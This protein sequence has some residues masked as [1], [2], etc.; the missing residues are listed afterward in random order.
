MIDKIFPRKLNRSKDARIQD[1]TEMYNAINISIDDFDGDNGGADG[2]GDAGV[3]KP[4]K[5]NSALSES[6]NIEE[7]EY[8]RVIGSVADEVNNE[9]YLFVFSTVLSKQGVYKISSAEQVSPVYTSEYFNFQSNGFVKGDIVYRS[10]GQVM[11]FFTDG[12]NEPRKLSILKD[13]AYPDDASS[14]AQKIDLITACPKT[15]MMPPTFQFTSDPS[16]PVNFRSVEGFQFAYQCIYKS[17]EESAISTYSNV[18]IP[19]P[20]LSQGS[21][22]D[23]LLDAANKIEVSVPRIVNQIENFTENVESIRL[24]VRIGNDGAF[25]TV[26][27]K[28]VLDPILNTLGNSVNFDFYNDSV[29]TGVPQEDQDKLNDALPKKALSQTVVNDRLIYGNYEEGYKTGQ[30][31]ANFTTRN[32]QRPEDFVDLRVG[33]KS[34]IAPAFDEDSTTTSVSI[35]QDDFVASNSNQ[36]DSVLNRRSAYQFDLSELPSV[37]P[38][39]S[40]AE[41]SF[42]ISPD[43]NFHLYDSL[44]G[45]HTFKNNGFG[46]GLNR[47]DSESIQGTTRV[48]HSGQQVGSFASLNG[49]QP[50][51]YQPNSNGVQGGGILWRSTDPTASQETTSQIRFGTSPSNP[52]VVPSELVTFKVKFKTTQEF[53]GADNV[54]GLV[55][56]VLIT[57]FSNQESLNGIDGI[58]D[59]SSASENLQNRNPSVSVDQLMSSSNGY[60]VISDN[61]PISNTV[62]SCFTEDDSSGSY[63]SN[64]APVGFFSINKA[65]V[66][67]ALRHSRKINDALDASSDHNVGP[68]F[69]LHIEALTDV[70][71]VTM[72]PRITRG[73]NRGWIYFT[74]DFIKNPDNQESVRKVCMYGE[75]SLPLPENGVGD[76]NIFFLN[77]N[78]AP[79]TNSGS[80]LAD[81]TNNPDT[82]LDHRIKASY[83]LNGEGLDVLDAQYDGSEF[84]DGIL[85]FRGHQGTSLVSFSDLPSGIG[86][87]LIKTGG[88]ELDSDFR[89]AAGQSGYPVNNGLAYGEGNDP[90][91]VGGSAEVS[92]LKFRNIGY[93]SFDENNLIKI[94][95]PNV[96]GFQ[97]S[98]VDG[99]A[100]IRQNFDQGR[101]NPSYWYG[102]YYGTQ[103]AG[104]NNNQFALSE[105]STSSTPVGLLHGDF[106]Y[107]DFDFDSEEITAA[108]EKEFPEIETGRNS[109][110]LTSQSFNTGALGRSFKRNCDHSFAILYYDERGRP[111]EPVSL[112]SH[113]VPQIPDSG[114]AHVVINL[115][116]TPPDWAHS[117]K[118]LYGGNTSISDFVQYTA[119]G[120]FVPKNSEQEKGL[121]YV[122][123]NY[124]QE[125]IDVSYSKAF[126]A[127]KSDGDKDL[128]TFS[129]GDRLRIVSF[130][131]DPDNPSYPSSGDPYE[132]QVV[133]TA[134]LNNDPAENPL[135][136]EGD[137]VHPAKT[138]QFVIIKDNSDA[139]G[140]SFSD[141]AGSLSDSNTT[142][143]VYD[144][145]NHWNKRCVFEI[146][147]PQ[148]KK[149]VE[150]RVYH[151]IGKTYNVVRAQNSSEPQHQTDTILVD[152][153]DVYFRKMA[154]NMQDFDEETNQFIGLIGDGT[155]TASEATSPNFR[156]FH[157]ESKAFTDTFP[158]ADVLPN[159][160]P[161][162]A[163]ENKTPIK[164]LGD[165]IARSS[166][167]Y[168][169]RNSSLKFSDRSNSNSN[170]VRY[171]SFN[172]SKLPFKDL[173][174]ND[175]EV[176]FLINQN[177]SVFCIQRLKCSSIPVARNILADALGNETVISTSKVL[178]TEKYYAGSYGTDSTTSVAEAGSA[179]YFVSIR[180]KEVYR[181]SPSSGIEV[182]SNKGMG[183]FFDET[184]SSTEGAL[185]ARLVGGY[186]PHSDEFI[187]SSFESV[188]IRFA[189]GDAP[190][191]NVVSNL[192][193]PDSTGFEVFE[194]TGEEG[195]GEGVDGVIDGDAYDTI[196][197]LQNDINTIASEINN[198]DDLISGL[199]DDF[200]TLEDLLTSDFSA[201]S[202]ASESIV[203]PTSDGGTVTIGPFS[204]PSAYQNAI[205]AVRL[206]TIQAIQSIILQRVGLFQSLAT[207]RRRFISLAQ[208]ISSALT[209]GS[210]TFSALAD[211]IEDLLG[212]DKIDL[213]DFI[214]EAQLVSLRSIE[215]FDQSTFDNVFDNADVFP[216]VLAPD[217]TSLVEEVTI[218]PSVYTLDFYSSLGDFVDLG[219]F[220]DQVLPEI[221]AIAFGGQFDD[222]SNIFL[223]S[224]EDIVNVPDVSAL[225]SN[226]FQAALAQGTAEG[227]AAAE[228]DIQ[229]AEAELASAR[230][231]RDLALKAFLTLSEA[232]DLVVG[233]LDENLVSNVQFAEIQNLISEAD[234]ADE[235]T[236]GILDDFLSGDEA[237]NSLL[238][239]F[240]LSGSGSP[241]RTVLNEGASV[242]ISLFGKTNNLTDAGEYLTEGYANNA[243][244]LY[245]ESILINAASVDGEFSG[246]ILSNDEGNLITKLEALGAIVN[247]LSVMPS[248]YLVDT[249][250]GKTG[251]NPSEMLEWIKVWFD[252]AVEV[253]TNTSGADEENP[254]II[255]DAAQLTTPQEFASANAPP[256]IGAGGG[257]P[258]I[259][260]NQLVNIFRRGL[261]SKDQ[262]RLIFTGLKSPVLAND[263]TIASTGV[264]GTI[265]EN[266]LYS[267]DFDVDDAVGSSDLIEFLSA[268]G[269]NFAINSSNSTPANFAQYRNVEFAKDHDGEFIE[270]FPGRKKVIVSDV[271]PLVTDNADYATNDI[272][273]IRLDLLN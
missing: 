162:V 145:N 59:V 31:K 272:V 102:V 219:I 5:G 182:I 10:E 200:T 3:I 139:S 161:R 166:S 250:A 169:V 74:E 214:V 269:S 222:A 179:I 16:R 85:T 249:P 147:S 188:E 124:L 100:G 79:V 105:G 255:F 63:A 156:S 76:C 153:G 193:V 134:T 227:I 111:G 226:I 236:I 28:S 205:E 261:I 185:N 18:A 238:P 86:D 61:D 119:G 142:Q 15:P 8:F 171:T 108:L 197:G 208:L 201:F 34:L 266:V 251:L 120:A 131:V 230:A 72:I 264:T 209:E 248:V 123:L 70:E 224:V 22:S 99:E 12:F 260:F 256:N 212:Q 95:D 126:G 207:S 24:L 69:T 183:S 37:L 115:D 88:T 23:P 191:S 165:V 43:R 67:F 1:K 101:L 235:T 45:F 150:S 244:G 53:Q 81:S 9:V 187:L 52:L 263:A 149:E 198:Q 41:L 14:A 258:S 195:T 141:V 128:Y 173:Q 210:E 71:T 25:F 254:A 218:L 240:Q 137:E 194:G 129:E 46:L 50:A 117:Y 157:L 103:Y 270:Y 202:S 215:A 66:K 54:K 51:V 56:Q 178:G 148:K 98:I 146:Y 57:F 130:F 77:K 133:G 151:E 167:N 82:L 113:F 109:F 44:N 73:G 83:F 271:D 203:I 259:K 144:N 94:S 35:V 65:E 237:V 234:L 265:T 11:L 127:V 4:V 170:I 106:S 20:F 190:F 267:A 213:S 112:G 225:V 36:A 181:F 174:T 204:I 122:S 175:G 21:L 158:N 247:G 135:A 118:I 192:N 47:S 26:S 125:N 196:V 39:Q 186:D 91:N 48:L 140:F 29:L 17:G 38:A 217:G 231:A 216:L 159:G 177:D 273:S 92:P 107:R 114:L 84:Y 228:P 80:E 32:I 223:D 155:N 33:I 184:L 160:K 220:D 239:L 233:G 206:E 78:F 64:V 252:F 93:I 143:G 221:D 62:V 163:L 245:G 7:G 168:Y 13:G 97:Y 58:E 68:V 55:E 246:D 89:V 60:G 40:I 257:T 138:G 164:L 152:Q 75:D 42:S 110:S 121:I 268:F 232:I 242:L 176:F 189:E 2:T 132:F 116:S 262:A 199:F 104:R 154:V 90:D 229:A 253:N 96:G 241:F 87:A 180:N 211:V 30:V 243:S 172:D 6:L 136:V 27:E 49:G 19:P